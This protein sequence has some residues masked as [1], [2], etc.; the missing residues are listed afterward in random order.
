M[1][2]FRLN[3]CMCGDHN[4]PET[5]QTTLVI[6]P[7]WIFDV[8]CSIAPPIASKNVPLQLLSPTC[9]NFLEHN[10]CANTYRKVSYDHG[11]KHQ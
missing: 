11:K 6:K 8:I 5:H 7:Q 4:M 2:L 3:I 9:L 1:L 10:Y